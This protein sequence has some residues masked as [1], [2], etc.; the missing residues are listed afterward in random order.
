M[1]HTPHQNIPSASH[2]SVSIGGTHSALPHLPWYPGPSLCSFWTA[3]HVG[4]SPQ[5]QFWSCHFKTYQWLLSR[6]RVHSN[7]DFPY[8]SR[9]FLPCPILVSNYFCSFLLYMDPPTSA[10][11]TMLK[12]LTV[13][14]NQLWEILKRWEYQATLPASWKTYASQ[15][16]TVRTGRGTM[17]WFKLGKEC[18]KVA[19][20]HPAYLTSIQSTLCEMPGWI[21]HKLESRLQGEISITSDMQMTPPLW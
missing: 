9:Y 5:T 14:H 2:I 4:Y 10:S 21:K 8:G 7:R 3:K 19:Y 6:H 12:P 18:A 15:E 13:D 17:D 1:T 16:A 11:L 20:F